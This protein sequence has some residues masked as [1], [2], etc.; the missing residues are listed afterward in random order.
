MLKTKIM[1][2]WGKIV[3]KVIVM[4]RSASSLDIYSKC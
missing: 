2:E 3:I 1:L 4:C